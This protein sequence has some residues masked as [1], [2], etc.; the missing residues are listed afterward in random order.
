MMDS[1]IF[2]GLVTVG[3]SGAALLRLAFIITQSIVACMLFKY[4]VGGKSRLDI[5]CFG[6]GLV[7]I[8]GWVV[9]YLRYSQAIYGAIFAVLLTSG[10]IAAAN[11][12]MI[13]KLLHMPLSEDV[14]AWSI[15]FCAATLTVISLILTH[16]AWIDFVPTTLTLLTAFLVVAIQKVQKRH[17]S[18]QVIQANKSEII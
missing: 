18:A 15:T 6:I 1:V 17:H 11:Y 12:N 13:L 7:A 8:I 16:A 10:A 3:F 14:T 9:I 5:I 4:G 2:A